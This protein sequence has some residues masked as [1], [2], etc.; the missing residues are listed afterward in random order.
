MGFQI[1][2][3]DAFKEAYELWAIKRDLMPS[4]IKNQKTNR[5]ANIGT[6]GPQAGHGSVK[7]G[8]FNPEF[9]CSQEV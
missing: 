3:T 9:D 7:C 4:I 5:A 6:M 2:A 1:K 8:L